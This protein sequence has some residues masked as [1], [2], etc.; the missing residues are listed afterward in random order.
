MRLHGYLQSIVSDRDKEFLSHFWR[1]L[2]RLVGTKLN[3]ST[4][5]HPQ[6][7]GQTEFVNRGVES[8]LRCFCGERLKE[9]ICWLHW[10]KYW[11]NT[12]YQQ[13]LEVTSFQAVYGR[14]PPLLISY[15]E[16]ATSN[17]ALD[18]QLKGRDV[19]LGALKKHSRGSQEEKKKYVDAKRREVEYQVGDKV[20]L[21]LRP[22]R[23]TLLRKKR[24]EELSPKFFRPYKVIERLGSVA[25]KLELPKE[26]AIHPVFH[27]PQLKS[28]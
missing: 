11:Y 6:T 21:K 7:D 15:G 25:D 10:A 17:S 9:W 20:F 22:Y 5:F 16:Q 24:N 2:F 12:I 14:L 28:C 18:E 26:A 8:Y 4:A 13:A 19:T 3:K 1:E 27:V 23:Q